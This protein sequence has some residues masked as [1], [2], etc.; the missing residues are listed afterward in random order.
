[1]LTGQFSFSS[2]TEPLFIKAV[3]VP[4]KEVGKIRSAKLI[5]R[6]AINKAETL[7]LK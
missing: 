6:Y 1:M 5:G 4:G 3:F 7:Y 2:Q